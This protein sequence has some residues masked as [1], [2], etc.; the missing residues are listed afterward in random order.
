MT[1][2]LTSSQIA[3]HR[4]VLKKQTLHKKGMSWMNIYLFITSRIQSLL[5]WVPNIAVEPSTMCLLPKTNKQKWWQRSTQVKVCNDCPQFSA[6]IWMRR[7]GCQNVNFQ[8]SLWVSR[9]Q[10]LCFPRCPSLKHFARFSW[11]KHAF[12]KEK[13]MSTWNSLKMKD[14]NEHNLH[15]CELECGIHAL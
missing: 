10:G 2:L 14:L 5:N 13:T 1:V 15:T 3:F 12:P 9:K 7:H 4:G 8:S 11:A 6:W